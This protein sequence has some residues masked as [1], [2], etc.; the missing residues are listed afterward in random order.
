MQ[1]AI[2]M[3]TSL[4][5]SVPA[6]GQNLVPNGSF[7]QYTSC[8][9]LGS[10][11]FLTGWENLHT[12]SA[13]YFNA[14]N[15]NGVVDVPFSECGYQEAFDGQ[16]YVGMATTAIGG[17]A[18]YREVVG[19]A[20]TQPLQ[21]GIP[22]CLSFQT[23]L[24]GFGR[25]PWNSTP[26]SSK[27]LG[28]K[29]FTA[30]PTDWSAYLYPNSAALH[31]DYVPIDTALWYGVSGVYIPDSAYSFIAVGNFFADSLSERTLI[32]STGY[33]TANVAYA[34]VDDVRV[35]FDL[36]FCTQSTPNLE[37]REP[38]RAF[39]MPCSDV[40]NVTL[41]R[42]MQGMLRYRILTILGAPIAEGTLVGSGQAGVP[43]GTLPNG[44][45]IL[46]LMSGSSWKQVVHVVHMNQ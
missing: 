26:Y 15:M 1:I 10:S 39:P 27:G 19:I 5:C 30:F 41:P 9:E 4:A 22:V 45:Y 28:L 12:T 37:D 23:A 6:R 8:P 33:G 35:S 17:A 44:S 31:I 25:V 18:W 24:G 36:S 2:A 38:I 46:E 40:L 43:F 34:F 3:I 16:A 11:V 21:P 32:D 29:F 7:E 13:D 42:Q 20:L 14:C